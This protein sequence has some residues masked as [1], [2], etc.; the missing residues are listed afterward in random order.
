M[1]NSLSKKYFTGS[2]L[3]VITILI[4]VGFKFTKNSNK[5]VVGIGTVKKQ[6]LIQRVTMAGTI[7]PIRKTVVMAP[8][9]GY[10]KKIFVK[11]GD[12]VKLGDP[13]AVVVQSLQSTDSA[14]PLRSPLNGVVVQLGKAEGEYIKEGDPKEFILR[15]DDNSKYEIHA[16]VPEIDRGKLKIGQDAIVNV[17][18]ILGKKFKGVINELS[19]AATQKEEFSRSQNVEFPVKIEITNSDD[20]VRG[21]LSAL[22][23]IITNKKE[24]ILML[25]HEY[26]R[27]ENDKYF[28]VLADGNRRDI[29]VGIQNEEGF[30]IVSGLKEG[31]KIKQIDFSEMHEEK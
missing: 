11:I 17:S 16:N 3:L 19:L 13:L 6:D 24:N 21:G 20:S 29:E 23:D 7:V 10:V 18:A 12:R 5:E 27:Q 8:Y 4:V 14:F 22:I 9:N 1:T 28:V 15:I 31:E 26:I 30:E 25:Q 2:I